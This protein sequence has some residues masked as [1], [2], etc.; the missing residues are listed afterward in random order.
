MFGRLLNSLQH[1]LAAE[2]KEWRALNPLRGELRPNIIV[3][4]ILSLANNAAAVG[5]SLLAIT[6]GIT[7]YTGTSSPRH[8]VWLNVSTMEI[9]DRSTYFS[10]LWAVQASM[11]TLVYPIVIGFIAMLLERRTNSK[12][13]LHVYLHHTAAQFAGLT[14]LLLVAA[15]GVQY[16]VLPYVSIEA[17]SVWVFV[18]TIWFLV[19][20]ALTIFFLSRTFAFIRPGP[21]FEITRRYAVTIAW[22]REAKR[23]LARNIFRGAVGWKL[24]PGPACGTVKDHEPCVLFDNHGRDSGA[25]TIQKGLS[26]KRQLNDVRFRLLAWVTTRWFI[27]ARMQGDAIAAETVKKGRRKD[28]ILVFPV[29][30]F[31]EYAGSVTICGVLGG[32]PLSR[33]E[34][35]LVRFAFK[36]GPIDDRNAELTT[37]D[38]LIGLQSDAIAALRSAEPESF[39]DGVTRLVE[40]FESLIAASEVK[41]TDGGR[42]N[43]TLISDGASLFERPIYL[44]WSYPFIT[45]FESASSKLSAGESYVS[46][47]SHIPNRLFAKN[48]KY[49]DRNILKHFISL[50]PILLRRIEAW[51]VQTVEQQGETTHTRCNPVD[52]RPPFFGTHERALREF[53]SAWETLKNFYILPKGEASWPQIQLAALNFEEHLSHT[54]VM[55]FDC[56][57]RG[58]RNGSEWLADVLIKWFAEL[59]YAFSGIDQYFFREQPLLTIDLITKGW[60]EVAKRV[61]VESYGV[62]GEVNKLAVLGV[63]L[64]NLW[65]D[66]CCVALYI[67]ATWGKECPCDKSLPARLFWAIWKG[68]PLRQGGSSAFAKQPFVDASSL[69]FAILRQNFEHATSSRDYRN[70]LDKY[71]EMVAELSRSEFVSGRLYSR[72]GSSDLDSLTDGQLLALLLA[73]PVRRRSSNDAEEV[74]SG[75]AITDND[76]LR[77]FHRLA[78][79]W[80]QRTGEEAF[81]EFRQEYECICALAGK[82]EGFSDALGGLQQYLDELI[83]V[84]ERAQSAALRETPISAQRLLEIGKWASSSGFSKD[85]GDLPLSLFAEVRHV[86]ELLSMRS[87]TI[88]EYPKGDLTDPPLANRASNESEWFAEIVKNYVGAHVLAEVFKELDRTRVSAN[89]PEIYWTEMQRFVVESK[90]QGL[91][92]VLV[93][94]NPLLPYWVENWTYPQLESAGHFVPS[95]LTVTRHREKFGSQYICSFNETP[96]FRGPLPSGGSLLL[97][98]ESLRLLE[99][100]RFSDGSSVQVTTQAIEGRSDVVEITITWRFKM[101]LERRPAVLLAYDSKAEPD[102]V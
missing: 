41:N 101:T 64:R 55:L 85:T 5:L 50:N 24:V 72:F 80:K 67:F 102:T 12:A 32:P 95:D 88:K 73:M 93:L 8:W 54:L 38:I 42:A 51:W 75:W 68:T 30:P 39:E 100:S 56:A 81:L 40:V 43:L 84:V 3:A 76:K 97:V 60:E 63:C 13:A 91:N 31:A 29:A 22:P 14:A 27:R 53:V 79:G 4:T 2:E 19:N 23:H 10:S 87:V 61:Q 78:R 6:L 89:A 58:D 71:S 69:M 28:V 70:R 17:T 35:L 7:L 62:T 45:I 11:V 25:H 86:T 74:L 57:L 77:D 65:I 48:L 59:E 21:R 1:R 46:F 90:A 18:D 44:D 36:F 49:G 52:L 83:A 99:F 34:K 92:P 66:V 33:I 82:T 15:M 98:R 94:E 16:L 96:V 20:V 47:L 9:A 26:S 37:K